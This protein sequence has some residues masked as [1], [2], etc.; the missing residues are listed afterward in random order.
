MNDRFYDEYS[1]QLKTISLYIGQNLKGLGYRKRKN[2]FNR[3]LSN[4]LIHHISISDYKSY[5]HHCGRFNLNF[6]CFLPEVHQYTK[7]TEIRKW[8]E[9]EH[10]QIKGGFPR[11]GMFEIENFVPKLTHIDEYLLRAAHELSKIETRD[12]ILAFEPVGTPLVV[13]VSKERIRICICLANDEIGTA[14][15]LFEQYLNR[16]QANPDLHPGA[17]DTIKNW[18]KRLKLS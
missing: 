15:E 2:T 3:T 7:G 6:G 4:G 8:I 9:V 18:G 12:A 11:K 16:S 13:A 14:K 17:L 10:C 1:A 5:S